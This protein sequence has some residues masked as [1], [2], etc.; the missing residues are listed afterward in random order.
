MI[1]KDELNLY[2]KN[3]DQLYKLFQKN[4]YFLP[5]N[6]KNQFVSKKMLMEVLGEKC[7]LPKYRDMKF[8]PCADPPSAEA[9]RDECAR[10]IEE[11]GAYSDP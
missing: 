5:V 7:L 1:T 6:I 8:L 10:I 11:N 2:A 3:R 4:G 9:L